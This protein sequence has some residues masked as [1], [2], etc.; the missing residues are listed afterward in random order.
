VITIIAGSGPLEAQKLYMD[1]AEELALKD[2]Y[3]VGAKPQPVLADLFST[4]SVGVFPSFEEPVCFH[5]FSISLPLTRSF[6][7]LH[8]RMTNNA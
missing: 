5:C 1:M 3:F 2:V 6:S 4:A 7:S 8:T